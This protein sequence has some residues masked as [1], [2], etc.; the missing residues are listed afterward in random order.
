VTADFLPPV[1]GALLPP[2]A[3]TSYHRWHPR[4]S[5]FLLSSVS[6]ETQIWTL[7]PPMR[8]ADLFDPDRW[9]SNGD[10]AQPPPPTANKEPPPRSRRLDRFLKGPI[11]WPWLARAIALPGKALAVGL[12]LWLQRGITGRRTVL[13]CLS[14]ATTHSIPTTT[15]R[16]AIRGLEAAGLVAI[17]RRPGRGLEVTL[18]EVMDSERELPNG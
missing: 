6:E 1:V 11:P 13:F 17:Q 12:M 9:Q 14:R 2:V 15:A 18:L 7:C 3:G 5:S 16:R 4:P 10:L 8:N